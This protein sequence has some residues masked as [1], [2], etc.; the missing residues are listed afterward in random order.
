MTAAYRALGIP[1][2]CVDSRVPRD[3][4]V[5]TLIDLDCDPAEEVVGQHW[6]DA[7]VWADDDGSDFWGNGWDREPDPDERD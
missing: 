7:D 5:A 3:G 4:D 2:T 6:T 1:I